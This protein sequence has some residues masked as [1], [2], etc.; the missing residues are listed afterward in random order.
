MAVSN[1]SELG[2][3]VCGPSNIAGAFGRVHLKSG[4]AELVDQLL[5]SVVSL[6][7]PLTTEIESRAERGRFG[8]RSPADPVRGLEHQ[9]LDALPLEVARGDQTGYAGAD[10]RHG[11]LLC[12]GVHGHAPSTRMASAAR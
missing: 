8:Q 1:G 6:A 4:R 11:G 10:D 9:H 3:T 2:E 7:D 12:F 5:K